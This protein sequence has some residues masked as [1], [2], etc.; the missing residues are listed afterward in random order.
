MADPMWEGRVRGE[1]GIWLH[2]IPAILVE[3]GC[4]S[5]YQRNSQCD[6][7]SDRILISYGSAED[8]KYH[9]SIKVLFV[10]ILFHPLSSSL[11]PVITT[12]DVCK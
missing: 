4:A 3:R 7:P 8:R 6:W 10:A 11:Q 1:V 9:L 12:K 5:V 2:Q